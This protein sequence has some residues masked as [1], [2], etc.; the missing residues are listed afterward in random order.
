VWQTTDFRLVCATNR[1]L[2]AAVDRG[3]FRVDLYYRI[4]GWVFRTPPLRERP[5]DILPLTAHFLEIFRS[6][7]V[8]L[9]PEEPVRE[10]LLHRKYPGNVRELRQLIQRIAHRHVGPGPITVGD[11]PE[12]DR[13]SGGELPHVWPDE[14]LGI[15]MTHAIDCG[16]GLKEIS[17]V[18]TETAIRIAVQSEGGNLQ[19]AAKRLGVTDRALQLR[20]ASGALH[21][22]E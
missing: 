14:H 19:R 13:P 17:Q 22:E 7:E 3:E 1:D 10:Y 8:P 15:A 5:E 6:G 11:I 21:V 4:A 20:R 2:A 12:D 9:E 16:A 18:T